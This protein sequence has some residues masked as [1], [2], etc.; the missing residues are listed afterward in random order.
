MA[1]GAGYYWPAAATTALTLLALWPLRILAYKGIERMKPEEKRLTVELERDQQ[2]GPFLA[3]LEHV[4]HFEL[5]DEPD[6]RV[7]QLELD[8]VD[9]KLVARLSDL[10]YV[11]GVRWRR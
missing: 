3:Q 5:S 10:P 6:R 9:E 4:R 2:I 11:I 8:D 1:C 7:V